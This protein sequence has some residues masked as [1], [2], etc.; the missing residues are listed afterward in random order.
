MALLRFGFA[1]A[2]A[3]TGFVLTPEMLVLNWYFKSKEDER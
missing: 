2:I 1:E 3:I